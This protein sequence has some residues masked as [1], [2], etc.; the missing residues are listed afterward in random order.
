MHRGLCSCIQHKV[1]VLEDR[2]SK[3]MAG[4]YTDIVHT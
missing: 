4:L 1:S 3:I 2:G